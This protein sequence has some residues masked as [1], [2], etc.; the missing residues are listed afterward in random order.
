MKSIGTAKLTQFDKWI[1]YIKSLSRDELHSMTWDGVSKYIDPDKTYHV[2]TLDYLANGGDYMEPM[3]HCKW[4]YSDKKQF[5][6]RML[7]YAKA[8]EAKGKKLKADGKRRMV[9]KQ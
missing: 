4:L 6:E 5:G 7:E 9:K 3:T 2:A 8:L 1:A